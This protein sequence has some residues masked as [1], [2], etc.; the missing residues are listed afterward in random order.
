VVSEQVRRLAGGSFDYED[1]GALTLK[2][3]AP[4]THGYRILGASGTASRFEAATEEGSPL[5]GRYQEI[6]LLLERWKLAQ[7]G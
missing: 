5:V 7:G 2:G 3:I 6:G 1:L 4:P